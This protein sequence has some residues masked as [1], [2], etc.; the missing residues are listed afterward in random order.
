MPLFNQLEQALKNAMLKRDP[1]AAGIFRLVKS[2]ALLQ[3]KSA[4]IETPS[5]E[6]TRA[7]IDKHLKNCQ[8]AMELYR[9]VG[10]TA[11]A[12]KQVG[13][14]TLLR[15]LLPAQ[16]TAAEVESLLDRVLAETRLE[17]V[18]HNFKALLEK[19]S[20]LAG[21]SASRSDLA[22]AIKGRLET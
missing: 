14:I 15:S 17:P 12:D 9:S 3:A 2:D 11:E 13:E 10:R 20:D 7:V 19:A 4:S 6:M 16:L 18:P 22:K 21:L 8:E 5:D 1:L